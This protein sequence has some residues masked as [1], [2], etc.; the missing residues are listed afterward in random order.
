MQHQLTVIAAIRYNKVNARNKDELSPPPSP[1]KNNSK[2]IYLFH[3]VNNSSAAPPFFLFPLLVAV[4][5]E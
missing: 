1:F 2:N 3:C 4:C 5:V